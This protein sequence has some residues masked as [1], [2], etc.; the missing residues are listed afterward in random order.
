MLNF[1]ARLGFATSDDVEDAT[2]V[3][4]ELALA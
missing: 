1:V 4:V 2:Q 3:R